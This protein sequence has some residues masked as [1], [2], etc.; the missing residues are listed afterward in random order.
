MP[1]TT[2]QFR[3]FLQSFQLHLQNLSIIVYLR[4]DSEQKLF[5]EKK[6]EQLEKQIEQ[7]T[8]TVQTLTWDLQ[9]QDKK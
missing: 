7:S 2:V 4:E 1:L 9:T 6:V 3:T 5:L 8:L